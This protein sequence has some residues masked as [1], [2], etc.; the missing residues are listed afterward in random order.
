MGF[1]FVSQNLTFSLFQTPNFFLFFS[2]SPPFFLSF[3]LSKIH[4]FLHLQHFFPYFSPPP[5]ILPLTNSPRIPQPRLR[6]PPVMTLRGAHPSATT[7]SSDLRIAC[8]LDT[9][10][11]GRSIPTN[12]GYS[13]ATPATSQD[14]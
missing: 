13:P 9:T 8:N 5:I 3:S 6:Q 4:H 10:T 12:S 2:F 1:D 11:S 7:N 14:L